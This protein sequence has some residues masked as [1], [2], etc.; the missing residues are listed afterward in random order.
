MQKE[1]IR[2][3]LDGFSVEP[4]H[5]PLDANDV[6]EIYEPQQSDEPGEDE[7]PQPPEL[8]LVGYRVA[9]PRPSGVQLYK[10]K[11]DIVAWKAA[12]AAYDDAMEA[13][14]AALA[15]YDPDSE[16][17]PPKPPPQVDLRTFWIE[18]LTQAEI[19]AIRNAPQPETDATKIAR[20][21]Q[22]NTTSM[23]AITEL[24]EMIIPIIM[25]E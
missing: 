2:I 6:T 1:A 11:Y 13:Y 21:E 25:P 10:P 17:E 5:V 15:A 19:D 24:F 14:H 12:I 23:L 16:D 18:G 4:E 20:L 9:V 7:E 22:Q 8:V 3:D